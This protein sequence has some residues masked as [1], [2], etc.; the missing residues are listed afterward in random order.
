MKISKVE[1]LSLKEVHEALMSGGITSVELTK[2]HLDRAEN[3]QKESNAFITITK[4][5]ALNQAEEADKRIKEKKAEL[6]TGIPFTVKD[7]FSTKDI[8]TTASSKIL[9]NYVPA[10]T[11]T[12]IQ[13][14][15]NA[16][17]VM[18]GKTNC[19]PFAFG[20]SNENSGYGP[21]KNP[22]DHTRVPGGSSGGSA[23][24]VAQRVGYFSIG[25]DTG[26]SIRQPAGFS[27]ISGLKVTYGRN[28]R[29][30]LLAM[31][32]SLDTPGVLS[33][34]AEDAAIV[35]SF[36]AGEDKNDATSSDN[37]PEDYYKNLEKSDIKKL[38]IGVAKEYFI[39][40]LDPQ[41]EKATRSAI[42]EFK[43]L[44]AEIVDISLPYTKYALAVYY[45]IVPSE[46]SSNMARY[47]SLRF[48]QT[49]GEKYMERVI[50]SREEFLEPEVK[51]RIMLGTYALS[52]GYYDAYYKKAMK[53]RTLVRQDFEKAF[54][55]VD[56]IIA[57][58][59]PTLPFKLGEKT[60]DPLQMYLAD[61]FTVPANIA[62]LPGLSFP[63]GFGKEKGSNNELPIG[64]QVIGKQFEELKVL[65]AVHAYQKATDWHK[66]SPNTKL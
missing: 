31:G 33:K 34:S 3:F 56:L 6:L 37:K 14:L 32:S 10:Y 41:V 57:P 48:G 17:A 64:V 43:K 1:E 66:K 19:D 45:V 12:V 42:E 44:G 16:G 9:D 59:S 24:S 35:E 52:A 55:K 25:S 63:A 60:D 38:K 54:E 7:V 18:I 2:Y 53:V 46:I 23:A 50:E 22:W 13:R 61:V 15:F 47:D 39:E 5:F 28:S 26:G 8:K 29:Y 65:S 4:E 11:A 21:V 36:M 40:G 27:G 20:A 62:G 51:R 30:G 58:T 49:K